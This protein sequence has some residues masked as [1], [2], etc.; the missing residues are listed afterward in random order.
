[1]IQLSEQQLRTVKKNLLLSVKIAIGSSI[2]ICIAQLLNLEYHSSAG[3]VT[4]L[5]L[6]TTRKGTVRLSILRLATFVGATLMILLIFM[7]LK[8]EWL[9]YGLYLFFMVFLCEMVD[10]R[11]TISV[12]AV[13][14]THFLVTRDF[15]F[16]FIVNEFLLVLI[17]VT[18]AFI[19]NLYHNT[20]SQREE[21]EKQVLYVEEKLKDILNDV[22]KYLLN[23]KQKGILWE[24]VG[25]LESE[26]QQFIG[27]AYEYYENAYE[28]GNQYYV[29]YFEMR[30]SQFH[31][32]HNLHSE[33]KKIRNMP[34]QAKIISD[35]VS[36]MKEY[37]QELNIPTAQV[38][39]LDEIFD[40]MKSQ[41]LP[42]RREE[43]EGRAVL[44]HIL[45][46]LEEFLLIKQRF[47]QKY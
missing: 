42:V 5:T 34:V 4:L 21:M 6:I 11:Q 36:Y 20:A 25:H 41:P 17:G 12:N 46:D 40:H 32:L 2:A 28:R 9:V 30:M 19:F 27:E 43:F 13:I 18:V 45:M 8:I 35:Y 29:D 15:S 1:M 16:N 7:P 33:M 26:I 10:L 47:V 24:E 31:I 22:A 44:Y 38:K 23:P 37:V 3:I 14:G 39:E